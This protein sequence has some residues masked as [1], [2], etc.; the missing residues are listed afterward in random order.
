MRKATDLTGK[1][2]GLWTALYRV[3]N[4]RHGKTQWMCQCVCGAKKVVTTNSL[5]TN[6]STSCGCNN[7]RDLTGQT[8]GDMHVVGPDYSTGRR[9]WR[10]SCRCG[11]LF[12]MSCGM[13][14]RKSHTTCGDGDG[15][16]APRPRAR[17]VMVVDDDVDL[18]ASLEEAFKIEGWETYC[19]TSTSD[20]LA[21]AH[22]HDFDAVV[23]DLMMPRMDGIQL[24]EQLLSFRPN[25][26]V[27]V[28]TG[29]ASVKRAVDSLRA[30][31][32]DFVPKPF[33]VF[34][35]FSTVKNAVQRKRPG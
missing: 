16:R 26:S 25:T 4:G 28:I 9:A 8:F 32:F 10:C 35:L 24:C 18:S 7:T 11:A 22:E 23:T 30:G 19:Q 2:Y 3:E 6:N 15:C 12:V 13:L 29:N 31:A 1:Q 5:V 21:A 17:S 34:D 27:V 14:C 33:N 20:A